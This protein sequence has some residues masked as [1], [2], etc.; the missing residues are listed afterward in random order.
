MLVTARQPK[1]ELHDA[2]SGRVGEGALRTLLRIGDCYQP[3]TI[4]TAV[5]AGRRAAEGL[6]QPSAGIVGFRTEPV[7][8]E[9]KLRH[10]SADLR[11]AE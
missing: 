3:G 11:A 8:T 5:F 4:A 6:D 2:L 1:T 10:A 9:R 7:A